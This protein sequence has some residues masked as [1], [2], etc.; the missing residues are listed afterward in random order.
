MGVDDM[1]EEDLAA[2]IECMDIE[3]MK[4]VPCARHTR[5][6]LEHILIAIYRSNSSIAL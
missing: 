4:V 3:F 2:T 1:E 5:K 6:L